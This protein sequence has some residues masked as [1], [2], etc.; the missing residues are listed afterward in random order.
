MKLSELVARSEVVAL[1]TA[2]DAEPASMTMDSRRLTPGA[3]FVCTPGM[4]RDAQSF[5]PDAASRGALAA[6]VYTSEGLERAV[7][8]GLAAVQ[9]PPEPTEFADRIW[10][11]CDTFYDH[12]TR[13]MKVVG[14]T[15]TNGKTTTAWLIRDMLA[16]LDV[17]AGY[18]GTLGFQ[19]PWEARTLDNTTPFAVE[20]YGMLAEARDRGLEALAIEISSHALATNRADGVEFDAAVF[21]NL[22]QDHL[23][24]HET[25]EAYETAKWRLFSE[26]P[27]RSSKKFVGALNVDDPTGSEW[28]R[29]GDF[30]TYGLFDPSEYDVDDW[31]PDMAD[32]FEARELKGHAVEIALDRLSLELSASGQADAIGEAKIGGRYNVSNLLSAS[33]GLLALDRSV[34]LFTGSQTK[35]D[36][37]A[38]LF[39]SVHPVPGRFEPIPNDLGLSVIVDYAHTPDAIEKLLTAVKELAIGQVV[40]VFGCGGDRDPGKRPKMAEAASRYSDLTVVTSDNPRTE[41]PAKIIDQILPGLIPGRAYLA[42]QDRPQ[43][44]TAAIA[45]AAPG[46]VVVICGKGHEDYQLIGRERIH[47]DDRELARNALRLSRPS[48]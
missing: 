7:S 37:I 41:D 48:P 16:A 47:M 13:R 9:L 32:A 45:A 31:S 38:S 10:R 39:S 4:T 23:D 27:Q 19:T 6:I 43:A 24:F 1:K 30:L 3:L 14:V 12:P 46:A 2:G 25:M 26:L 33:A 17:K 20:L 36:L 42:I 40:T 8:L 11:L 28:S 18:L 34:G 15:G 29:K 5:L 22:T 35:L 44:V 21:T